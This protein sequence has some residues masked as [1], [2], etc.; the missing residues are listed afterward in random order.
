MKFG[1]SGLSSNKKKKT[2]AIKFTR[3]EEIKNMWI[4]KRD[5]FSEHLIRGLHHQW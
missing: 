2:I 5:I 4:V 3:K 1:L